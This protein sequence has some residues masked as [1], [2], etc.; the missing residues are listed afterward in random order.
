VR[1]GSLQ[2]RFGNVEDRRP[3]STFPPVCFAFAGIPCPIWLAGAISLSGRVS[4][5]GKTAREL[6]RDLA[7]KLGAKYLQSPQVTVAVKEYNSQRVTIEGAVKA[8]GV[9]ALKG[10]TSLL[11]LVAMSGGLDTATSD[12]T[13]VIFRHTEGKRYAAMFDLG[14]IKKGEAQDPAILPGDVVVA[15]SSTMKAVWGD[16]LKALPIASFALLLL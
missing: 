9:H 1:S 14:P 4:V 13:L 5:A 16:F 2:H 7:K 15:N 12:S 11:Q 10:K 8:P 6:E 3:A